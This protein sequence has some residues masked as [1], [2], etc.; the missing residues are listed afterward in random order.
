MNP[1][2]SP[3]WIPRY[4]AFKAVTFW[5]LIFLAWLSYPAEN[6]YSIMSH[7][8]SFLGSWSEEHNPRWWWIFSIAMVFWGVATIPLILFAYKRFQLVS[9]WAA[10]VGAILM[11]LGC[12]GVIVVGLVP[13]ARDP[14]MG[15]MRW[16]DIHEKAA[17]LVAAGFT[18]GILWHAGMIIR[19]RFTDRHFLHAH[20]YHTRA[21]L[22][23]FLIWTTVVAI[24]V[25]NQI[26]WGMMYEA[27][28]TAALQSGDKIGSSWGESLNTVYAFPLWENV[29]IYTLFAVLVWFMVVVHEPGN[30]SRR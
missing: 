9:R 24:A 4:A 2:Q 1:D 30:N 7:T 15:T 22:W 16:T 26:R 11:L 18:L 28:K 12:L 20:G 17:V 29:V 10:A 25:G 8:F 19:D 5:T 3:A 14:F 23:P 21:F 27:R 13:D 6:H